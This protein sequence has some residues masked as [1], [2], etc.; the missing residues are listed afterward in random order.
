M[1]EVNARAEEEEEGDEMTTAASSPVAVAVAVDNNSNIGGI[2]SG[3]DRLSN[4]F[5]D[6][7]TSQI[8]LKASAGTTTAAAASGGSKGGMAKAHAVTT[9][10]VRQYLDNEALR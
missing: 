6:T 3:S 5:L 2:S 10:P 4:S 1:A 8:G 9:F 7:F